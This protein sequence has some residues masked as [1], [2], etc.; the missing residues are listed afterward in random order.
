MEMT[1]AHRRNYTV[2]TA[3][4]VPLSSYQV[5]VPPVSTHRA[6]PPPASCR[7]VRRS[8]LPWLSDVT[9][10]GTPLLSCNLSSRSIIDKPKIARHPRQFSVALVLTMGQV[11]LTWLML[12]SEP[13]DNERRVPTP[14]PRK[15]PC[16]TRQSARDSKHKLKSETVNPEKAAQSEHK[17]RAAIFTC[18]YSA[19]YE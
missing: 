13:L 10:P 8:S 14:A 1:E 6:E 5:R 9:P 7:H 11:S 4:E 16:H 3:S 18:Q 17:A 19:G 12:P 2:L 15:L